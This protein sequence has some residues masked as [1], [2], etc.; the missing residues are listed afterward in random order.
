LRLNVVATEFMNAIKAGAIAI[1][2]DNAREELFWQQL[3]QGT[4]QAKEAYFS[5]HQNEMFA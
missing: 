1:V 3:N 4:N 2:G 5:K